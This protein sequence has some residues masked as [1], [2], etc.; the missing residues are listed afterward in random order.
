MVWT[1]REG[2]RSHKV[3]AEDAATEFNRI[4]QDRGVLQASILVEESEPESA[5]C[6]HEFEW[7]NERAAHKYRLV[8][9]RTLI[10]DVVLVEE[11]DSEPLQF[12]HVPDDGGGEG[13]YEFVTHLVNVR[14]KYQV[15]LG[16][17]L[18]KLEALDESVKRL[19]LASTS[20]DVIGV[21]DGVK[22]TI[23][24]V[25]DSIEGLPDDDDE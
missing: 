15:A 1:Y 25:R 3:S 16:E 24:G 11:S 9:A 12:Y 18:Q 21:L 14:S 23:S 7:D 19:L 2:A 17:L 13:H 20:S 8:Q 5:P 10:R 4:K 6:H 22:N